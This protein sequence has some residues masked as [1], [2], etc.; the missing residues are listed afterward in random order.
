MKQLIELARG[1]PIKEDSENFRRINHAIYFG[2]ILLIKEH[3]RIVGY[4]EV[5][6]VKESPAYPV[7]PWPID[8]PAGKILYCWAAAC[9]KGYIKKLIDL[10]KRTFPEVN[11]ICW[12]RHKRNNKIHL[13]RV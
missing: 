7:T 11:F 13:E 12:H 8:D 4:A 10:A 6:R 1:L 5:Y 2:H 3:G 9:E